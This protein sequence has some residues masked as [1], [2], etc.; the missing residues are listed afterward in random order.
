MPQARQKSWRRIFSSEICVQVKNQETKLGTSVHENRAI[1]LLGSNSS[2][3]GVA[4]QEA[5]A[6][7]GEEMHLE[8]KGSIWQTAAW[9][10]EGPDFLNQAVEVRWA[11]ALDNLM[12]RCLAVERAMGR[13]RNPQAQGYENRRMDIDIILWS[14]GEYQSDSVI[15]PHPRMEFRRFVLQPLAEHWGNWNHPT[16]NMT[17]AELLD[18]CSD[19]NLIH[20]QQTIEN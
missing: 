7:L 17:V 16:L 15:V 10:F 20:L 19:E 14:K 3:A 1:L 18:R 9:G 13:L 11:L 8:R 4:L 12:E 2:D 5:M 6:M